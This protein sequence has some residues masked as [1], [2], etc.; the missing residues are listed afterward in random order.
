MKIPNYDK[1][2]TLE[3]VLN[4]ISRCSCDGV[5]CGDCPILYAPGDCPQIVKELFLKTIE[6]LQKLSKPSWRYVWKDHA[7]LEVGKDYIVVVPGESRATILK[8]IGEDEFV[9]GSC[10]VYACELFIPLPEV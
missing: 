3:D 4:V 6:E 2:F 8:Y 1:D 9:D 10:N 5:P 7:E